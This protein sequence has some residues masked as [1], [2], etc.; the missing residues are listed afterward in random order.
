VTKKAKTLVPYNSLSSRVL[1]EPKTFSRETNPPTVTDAPVKANENGALPPINL[2][3]VL[4]SAG[5]FAPKLDE[6]KDSMKSPRPA[7]GE[8]VAVATGAQ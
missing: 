6:P 2:T 1:H 5:A 3:P 7:F 8:N 4:E